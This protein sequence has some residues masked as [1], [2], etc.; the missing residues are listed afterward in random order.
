MEDKEEEKSGTEENIRGMLR[1]IF[2]ALN[3]QDDAV[4]NLNRT[5]KFISPCILKEFNQDDKVVND[6]E[7][8]NNLAE[9]YEKIN[10]IDNNLRIMND[11]YK[12][13]LGDSDSDLPF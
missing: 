7:L 10:H 6:F 13:H 12:K 9:I 8:H 4:Y 1:L 3:S 2:G 11:S 5:L